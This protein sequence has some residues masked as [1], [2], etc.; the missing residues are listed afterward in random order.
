[1]CFVPEEGYLFG[2]VVSEDG[3]STDPSKTEAVS[4]WP[5]PRSVAEVR[6]LSWSD[7]LLSTF[8]YQYAHIA[9]PLT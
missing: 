2:H 9:K 8:I 6:S 5:V 7:V 1:M 4:T 3:V